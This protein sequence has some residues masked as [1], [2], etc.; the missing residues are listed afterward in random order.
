MKRNIIIFLFFII[1]TWIVFASSNFIKIG[2]NWDTYN[3]IWNSNDN[4]VLDWT[5]DLEDSRTYRYIN[6]WYRWK[7]TWVINSELFW[8]FNIN[9]ELKLFFNSKIPSDLKCWNSKNLELYD[10]SWK[11]ESDYWWEMEIDKSV[12]YFCSNKYTFIKF[13]SN[14][15]GEKEIWNITQDSFVDDFWKQE[16]SIS[17]IS[18]IKWNT[19]DWILNRWDWN[20]NNLSVSI[21][22][23][24]ITNIFLNKN[25]FT[26]FK[27]FKYSIK[28]YEF[29]LNNFNSWVWNKE[30]FYLYYYSNSLQK[31]NFNWIWDYKN[32][33]KILQIWNS[34]TDIIKIDWVNTV[35]VKSWNIY[36]NSNLTNLDNNWN[37]NNKNLLILIAKRDKDTGKWWNIYINPDVT[38]IDAILIVDWSLISLNW[39]YIQQVSNLSQVNN[40]RKQL[41]IY[42][43]VLSSNVV[44]T[45]E[46]PYWSDY[47]NDNS[48]I[49]NNDNIYDL[50][51]LRTFNLNYWGWEWVISW[52]NDEN[53]LT[54]IN[55]WRNSWAGQKECYIDDLWNIHLRKSEKL[56]PLIIEYN[57]KI[58]LLD[59]MILRQK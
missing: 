25:I 3:Y 44:W 37:D 52:C 1:W 17:W 2:K 31:L 50:W 14:S 20:F 33:W 59:P 54:P 26:L 6:D 18:K 16:I 10:I 9:N 47:Y 4:F 28:N 29:N 19:N 43:S 22:K 15:L 38:N 48:Y 51:N 23:K 32:V 27:T 40:L 41:L 7:I 57:N 58:Q 13:L 34:G 36:I 42:G 55:I 56:N 5:L 53:K 45:D 12:S 8:D 11:I 49:P 30:N 21:S 35:I 24:T 46:I 39:D